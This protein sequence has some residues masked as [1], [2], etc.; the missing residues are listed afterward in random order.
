MR[1]LVAVVA[2]ALSISVACGSVPSA[3][4]ASSPAGEPAVNLLGTLDRGTAQS[5]PP[6]DPCDPAVVGAFLVFSQPGKPDIRTSVSGSGEFA[7]H[8]DPGSYTISAAPS[9]MRGRL[10]PGDV[11]VPSTGAVDLH[12]VVVRT[13]A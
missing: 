13:P 10:Q 4:A 3:P 7:L 11:R 8:L 9:P 12:L 6:G 2:L 5:C 1:Q